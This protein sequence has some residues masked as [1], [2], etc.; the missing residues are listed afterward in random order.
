MGALLQRSKSCRS[1]RKSLVVSSPSPSLSR[2]LS[3]LSVPT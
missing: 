2:P 1:N 3:P